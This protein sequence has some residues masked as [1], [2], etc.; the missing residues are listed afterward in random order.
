MSVARRVAQDVAARSVFHD[1][2]CLNAFNEYRPLI[3]DNYHIFIYRGNKQSL[4][5][6]FSLVG[7]PSFLYF[8]ASSFFSQAGVRGEWNVK[9]NERIERKTIK[10]KLQIK[11][12]QVKRLI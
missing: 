7:L 10:I 4:K 8:A 5:R 1:R 2:F 12:E 6:I 11:Y 9:K 3:A